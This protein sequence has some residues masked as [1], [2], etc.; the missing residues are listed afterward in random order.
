M[1]VRA[2]TG[3]AAKKRRRTL[4]WLYSVETHYTQ[5]LA[6][7]GLV[8]VP[9]LG[10]TQRRSGRGKMRPSSMNV[11]LEQASPEVG[12]VHWTESLSTIPLRSATYGRR[13]WSR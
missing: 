13:T 1:G 5:Q 7:L 2:R 9:N 8:W 4:A 6:G 10:G 11:M 12:A 3:V